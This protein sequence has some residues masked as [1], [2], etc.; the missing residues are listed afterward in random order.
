MH[1]TI[2]AVHIATGTLGALAGIAAL[3]F[4]KGSAPHR[5]VGTVFVAVMLVMAA[6]ASILETM[7]PEPGSVVGG[8]M[9][10]YFL[11]T[12][13][14]AGRRKD[15]ETGAFEIG[16][17]IA[18]FA[19]AALIAIGAYALAIGATKPPNPIFPYV[20]YGISSAMML[21][22][23]ADL[24][25]ILRRGLTGGQRIARHL[26]RM[27]FALFISVGS[28]AAQGAKGL[29]PGVGSTVLVTSMLLI[30]GLMLFWLVRV[31]MTNWYGQAG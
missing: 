21:A 5:V 3:F 16:A 17:F 24:R 29:P 9:T 28:F 14:M 25:V 7:K 30:F 31:R 22:A 20:L 15:G 27:C 6:T 23:L 1:A 12:A 13:W 19:L 18:A 8:L 10:I 2:L 4:R 26:W 11:A